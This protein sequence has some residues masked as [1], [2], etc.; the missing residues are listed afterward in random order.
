MG[1]SSTDAVNDHQLSACSEAATFL[2]DFPELIVIRA[3][4]AGKYGKEYIGEASSDLT[5]RK[6]RVNENLIR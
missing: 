3:Q 2:Q 6:W 4:L 5:C 1:R